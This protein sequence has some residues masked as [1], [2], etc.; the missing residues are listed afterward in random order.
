MRGIS[1]VRHPSR[2]PPP[3]GWGHE[4]EEGGEYK[5]WVKFGKDPKQSRG[6]CTQ[7][8]KSRGAEV[9]ECAAQVMGGGGE[10]PGPVTTQKL[11]RGTL[12]PDPSSDLAAIC[13]GWW[14]ELPAPV[15]RSA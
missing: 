8:R 3:V 4:G 14:L 6:I 9:W 15:E 10:A 11:P 2:P 7:G 5:D 1:K 13:L 12:G